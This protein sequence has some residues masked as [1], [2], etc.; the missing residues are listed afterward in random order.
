MKDLIKKFDDFAEYHSIREALV[1]GGPLEIPGLNFVSAEIEGD[2][3]ILNTESGHIYVFDMKVLSTMAS[4]EEAVAPF[5]VHALNKLYQEAVKSKVDSYL[6]KKLD[7]LRNAEAF[8]L[9]DDIITGG[10]FFANIENDLISFGMSIDDVAVLTGEIY[11]FYSNGHIDSMT[12]DGLAKLRKYLDYWM[13]VV[14]SKT[15]IFLQYLNNECWVDKQTVGPNFDQTS[16]KNNTNTN[17]IRS[18]NYSLLESNS[19]SDETVSFINEMKS[20][21]VAEQTS[22][23][24]QSADIDSNLKMIT[25]IIQK[26][27]YK[28]DLLYGEPFDNETGRPVTMTTETVV[29][30]LINP[31]C[32]I[33]AVLNPVKLKQLT[34]NT[35]QIFSVHDVDGTVVD[36]YENITGIQLIK[37]LR[38]LGN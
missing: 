7:V 16:A 30:P 10:G 32:E 36:G 23:G 20:L 14:A 24:I 34:G 6:P 37:S 2:D 38:K 1:L 35:V 19:F 9:F 17:I 11:N 25:N 18:R 3:I 4:D 26:A 22:K 28:S 5:V 31:P 29:F 27:C 12:P 21:A 15:Y 13:E 33:R 8:E